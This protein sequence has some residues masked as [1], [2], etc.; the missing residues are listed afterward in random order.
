MGERRG[1][2]KIKARPPKL[3]D[4]GEGVYRSDGTAPCGLFGL[5]GRVVEPEGP[6][7]LER[8]GVAEECGRRLGGGGGGV[9]GIFEDLPIFKIFVVV[10]DPARVLVIGDS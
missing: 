5:G 10:V 4:G 8:V 2:E 1:R 9:V 3:F 7:I 6:G